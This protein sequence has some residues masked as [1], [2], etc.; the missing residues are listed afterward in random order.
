VFKQRLLW[1]K[2][3]LP[4]HR[5]EKLLSLGFVFDRCQVRS[6]DRWRDRFQE[7]VAFK[8]RH[9][10]CLVP[11][12]GQGPSV[13]GEWVDKQQKKH[14]K[15]EL[16]ETRLKLLV[17]VGFVFSARE[18][19]WEENFSRLVESK[20]QQGNWVHPKDWVTRQRRFFKNGSLSKH[21]ERRL[22]KI[23]FPFFPHDDKWLVFFYELIECKKKKVIAM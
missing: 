7:L 22:R 1:F 5:E 19:K 23:G 14:K 3:V 10:H 4:K 17:K 18:H 6:S 9:G 16:D 2:G 12:N 11:R 15:K 13:L 8:K 20:N 21:H